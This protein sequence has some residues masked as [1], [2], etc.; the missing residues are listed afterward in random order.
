MITLTCIL[1][2]WK[3]L[4]NHIDQFSGEVNC[5]RL[6]VGMQ[7]TDEVTLKKELSDFNKGLLDNQKAKELSDEE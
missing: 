7:D 5:C 2:G 3:L 6:L 1:R 4:M